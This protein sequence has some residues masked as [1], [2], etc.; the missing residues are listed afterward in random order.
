[1]ITFR[2]VTTAS[3]TP[4]VV[5]LPNALWPNSVARGGQPI[6]DR[7]LKVLS[8]ARYPALWKALARG[9]WSDHESSV[10]DPHEAWLA[11]YL[12]GEFE[13]HQGHHPAWAMLSAQ[14][15]AGNTPAQADFTRFFVSPVH[16]Q[17]AREGVYLLPPESLELSGD[18]MNQLMQVVRP[19][20][21]SAG[22]SLSEPDQHGTMTGTCK[23]PLELSAPSPWSSSQLTLADYLPQ[24][25]QLRAWRALWMDIQVSLHHHPV[26]QARVTAGKPAVNA[27][28]WWGGGAQWQAPVDALQIDGQHGLR[29]FFSTL[30]GPAFSGTS[31]KAARIIVAPIQSHQDWTG[32]AQTLAQW[33]A[34]VLAPLLTSAAPFEMVLFGQSGWRR[35]HVDSSIRWKLWKNQPNMNH[36]LEPVEEGPSEESLR[37][38]YEAGQRDQDA[39]F[40][41]QAAER[42]RGFR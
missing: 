30:L 17:L 11:S 18:E 2:A 40:D 10:S 22:W 25:E 1:M 21:E 15:E 38:A 7:L 5:V 8:P 41:D 19:L 26:N 36:L 42:P 29:P 16:L 35:C 23:D 27:F 37:S 3:H 24:G 9:R 31:G 14:S 6:E 20:C 34:T 28:W 39:L 33:D 32:T 13:G 12:G 4:L